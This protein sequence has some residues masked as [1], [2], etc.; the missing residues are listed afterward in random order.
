MMLYLI[1][2][3][4]GNGIHKQRFQK[5]NG[6]DVSTFG[7]AIFAMDGVGAVGATARL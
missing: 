7:I 5:K 2:I 1:L 3:L 6:V 4:L